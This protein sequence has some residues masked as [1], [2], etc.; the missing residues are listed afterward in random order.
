MRIPY[1]QL[2]AEFNRV[3]LLIGFTE[4]NADAC[5]TMFANN[6]RDGVVSHG[7]NRFPVFVEYVKEGLVIPGSGP[8]KVSSFGAIEQWDGNLGP[9]PLNATF[10][11]ARA[12]ALAAEYGIGC[13]AIKNTNHWMRGGSY[14]LQAADAG[15][16]CICFSNTKANLPPWGGTE[17]RLGNNPLVIAVPKTGGHIVLDMALSQYSF[18][19]LWQ[20]QGQQ[21]QLPLPGGY[22]S[23]GNLTNDAEAIMATKRALPIGFW[24]GSGL[25]LMLDLL[26]TVLSGG[27][28]TAA[29]TERGVKETGV[30]QVFICIKADFGQSEDLITEIIAYAKSSE[31][32]AGEEIL[33][34]GENMLRTRE[35]NMEEGVVV[36]PEIWKVV[37]DM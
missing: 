4:G 26:A 31:V 22:D 7:L 27:N 35:K 20:Y 28:S 19:K 36:D 10:C 1:S 30:S 16:L 29:I 25:S 21:K 12:I 32:I 24:K 8:T 5:A 34:P 33:Y 13:I 17:P 15:Y 9:G 18:G 37:R 14:G 11:T 2:K 23:E 6:S 3:L